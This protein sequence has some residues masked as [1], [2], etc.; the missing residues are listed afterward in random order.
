MASCNI[1]TCP[2]IT[3]ANR[4]ALLIIVSFHSFDSR[5]RFERMIPGPGTPDLTPQHRGGIY[6]WTVK[7]VA[8][9]AKLKA[10]AKLLLLV[11]KIVNLIFGP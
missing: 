4:L 10:A 3:N 8:R 5:K 2:L 6:P 9:R 7:F 1:P 11:G